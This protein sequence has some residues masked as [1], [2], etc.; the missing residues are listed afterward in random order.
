MSER[1]FR[2]FP[3]NTLINMIEDGDCQLE[4]FP[5]IDRSTA[6]EWVAPAHLHAVAIR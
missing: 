2:D 4:N 3:A 6:P 1:L 5:L